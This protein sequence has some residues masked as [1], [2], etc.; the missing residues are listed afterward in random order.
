LRVIEHVIIMENI[1]HMDPKKSS[2]TRR[3]NLTARFVGSTFAAVAGGF[4]R[5]LLS[6]VFWDQIDL[7][8]W[9]RRHRRGEAREAEWRGGGRRIEKRR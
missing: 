3:F 1:C 8:C 6:L 9:E 4:A 2:K 7:S 5:L